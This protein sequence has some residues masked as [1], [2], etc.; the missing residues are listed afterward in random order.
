MLNK[1]SI[2]SWIVS[3]AGMFCASYA[4]HGMFLNDLEKI[5]YPDNVFVSLAGVAYLIIGF[6]V[7]FAFMQNIFPNQEKNPVL[8][9]PMIGAICGAC[10][11]IVVLVVSISFGSRMNL[12]HMAFDFCWQ[13]MEQAIGGLLVGMV[14]Y[15]VTL[16]DFHQMHGS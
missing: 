4:W 15:Y 1:K 6:V 9:G 14:H 13:T 2:L 7:A 3:S 12:T 11:Y 8:R 16:Y 5:Q 10:I